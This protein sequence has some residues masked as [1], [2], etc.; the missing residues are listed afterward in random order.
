MGK[1]VDWS[2]VEADYRA[3]IKPL[4]VIAS[5]HGITHG[6]IRK[7][8]KR[9]GWVQDLAERIRLRAQEKVSKSAVSKLV[10]KKT[11]DTNTAV[12]EANAAIQA[13]IILDHRSDI[14]SLRATVGNMGMELS[15]VSN[16]DLQD[17]LDLVLAEKVTDLSNAQAKAALYKA[18]DA[19]L[20]LNGRSNTVK[21]L[22][23]SLAVLIDKE[24]Q[25]FGIDKYDSSKKSLGEWLD[26]LN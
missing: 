9:D 6:A 3:G 8:A 24:R 15:S 11:L 18:H 14:R 23:Q 21:N 12:V 19:A 7:R 13:D 17:A 22:V 2:A 1:D 16:S 5:S 20:R 4:R 25:A 10:S 26:S